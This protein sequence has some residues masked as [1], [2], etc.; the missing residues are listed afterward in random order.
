[1]RSLYVPIKATVLIMA[2]VGREG[3]LPR[4]VQL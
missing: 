3:V 2:V 4:A 1:V